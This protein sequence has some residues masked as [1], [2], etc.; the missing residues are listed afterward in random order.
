MLKKLDSKAVGPYGEPVNT[1]AHSVD[2]RPFETA[3]VMK[4]YCRA[5]MY[6]EVEL[7]ESLETAFIERLDEAS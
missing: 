1:D 3:M 2:L 6:Q 5:G 4:A 7:L